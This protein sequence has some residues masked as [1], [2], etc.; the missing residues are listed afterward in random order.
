[1]ESLSLTTL[2]QEQLEQARTSSAGRSARTL[3]GGHSK[4]RQTV[5]AIRAEEALGEHESPDEATLQVLQ[6]RVRMTAGED[7]WEGGAGDF[8]IIPEHR[9]DLTALEDAVVL[10]SAFN[11]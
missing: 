8:L 2:A 10:L 9:H 4:L 1:M 11:A 5:I 3:H 7:V 6:G